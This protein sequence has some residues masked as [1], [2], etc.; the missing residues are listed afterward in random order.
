MAEKVLPLTEDPGQAQSPTPAAAEGE[1]GPSKS[2]LKKAQKEKEKAEKA[3]KRAAAEEAQK[4]AAEANDVS[5]GDYGE[6]PALPKYPPTPSADVAPRVSLAQLEEQFKGASDVE[7]SA[8]SNVVFRAQVENARSQSANLAF[9]VFK[10]GAS[11]IQ[12]V[13]AKSETLSK[14]VRCDVHSPKED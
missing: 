9:L 13:V 8:G 3:A 1:K 2:A 5:K 11:T 6:L 10:Q 14:Q 7:P 4:K 12:A